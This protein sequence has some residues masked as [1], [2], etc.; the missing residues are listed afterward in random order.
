M[1]AFR[2]LRVLGNDLRS[3]I[4]LALA[5]PPIFLIVTAP[6]PAAAENE[7]FPGDQ[8]AYVAEQDSGKVLGYIVNRAN[9]KLTPIAGSPFTTGSSGSTSVAVDP[10]GR[11]LYATN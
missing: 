6:R 11:F 3:F 5:L 2:K 1:S 4:Y 7:H 10:A 9:G 8:F